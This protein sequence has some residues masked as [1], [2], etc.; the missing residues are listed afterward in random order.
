MIGALNGIKIIDFTRVLAGPFCTMNLADMGAEVIKIEH[1]EFGDD[2]RIFGPFINGESSYF[3]YVNRGKKSITLDLKNPIAKEIV[4]DLIREADVV[5]ENF[6]PGVMEK[7][8][9]GYEKL[10][11]INSGII[12]CSIS[13][14]GQYS[15]YKFRPAY[16]LVAQAM[17]GIM[18]ITG[19]PDNPPAR[20]G[21]S[22]GDISAGLY[23]AFGITTALIHKLK[24]GE[25]QYIDISM[26]DSVF[27]FLE[28]NVVRYTVGK[29]VPER[30][31]SRHPL[32]APFDSYE[33]KDGLVIIAIASDNHFKILCDKMGKP[34]L[35]NDERF[36]ED[37][38]REINEKAL[39]VIIE[40][41]LSNYTVDE[42]MEIMMGIKI[43]CGPILNIEQICKDPHIELR[44]MLVDVEHPIAGNLRIPG[45]PVKLSVTP[46]M[47]KGAAPVLG[48]HNE[49]VL[50]EVIGYDDSKIKS[51]KDNGI[52]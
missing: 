23:A 47:A 8:G 24:T 31:G 10:R 22:L 33:C 37:P 43:P 30:I 32:S 1:P 51:L 7:L 35:M 11:E 25:G 9:F 27:S 49:I 44:E 3:I 2:S 15:P 52:I 38:K 29:I 12:Y 46:P 5:I 45:N 50:R 39:K 17:G 21:S 42:A 26:L 20:V 48:Q 16:D 19:F 6:K 40:S 41:W 14:F 13:G 18:S 4:F 34:E 36:S 28:S